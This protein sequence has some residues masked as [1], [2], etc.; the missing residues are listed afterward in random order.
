MLLIAGWIKVITQ[1]WQPQIHTL[2][3]KIIFIPLFRFEYHHKDSFITKSH[4]YDTSA[5]KIW[6]IWHR[7]W[8]DKRM[9]LCDFICYCI[10]LTARVP[11]SQ[12]P[13]PDTRHA[14][15]HRSLCGA[16]SDGPQISGRTRQEKSD[17]RS[18]DK[19]WYF[20]PASGGTPYA[21]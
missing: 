19:A 5:V 7:R 6:L 18:S 20:S 9:A 15:M 8:M 14:V 11:R 1:I 13:S 17:K 3:S 2:R 12:T 21:A 10:H 4:L 16:P